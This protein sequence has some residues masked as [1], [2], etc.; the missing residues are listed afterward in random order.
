MSGLSSVRRDVSR[1]DWRHKQWVSRNGSKSWRRE[2]ETG[3]Y[4][5]DV[6]H[7]FSCSFQPGTRSVAVTYLSPFPSRLLRDETLSPSLP[8]ALRGRDDLELRL[9]PRRPSRGPLPLRHHRHLRQS[10]GI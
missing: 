2:L 7:P 3:T 5:T 4:A 9:R 6:W 1:R 10:G 8:P